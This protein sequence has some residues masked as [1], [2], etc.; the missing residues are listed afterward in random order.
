MLNNN[1]NLYQKHGIENCQ[2]NLK[3]K[4]KHLFVWLVIITN[5]VSEKKNNGPKNKNSS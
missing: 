3:K 5:V 4:I 2:N 1:R